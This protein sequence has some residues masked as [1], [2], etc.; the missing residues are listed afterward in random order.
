[1]IFQTQN[2]IN[3]LLIFVFCGIISALFLNIL[4]CIFFINYQKNIKK[5]ILNVV[6]YSFFN[7]FFIFLLNFFNF[8]K[9][10]FVLL[11]FFYSSFLVTKKLTRKSVVLIEKKCYNIF[12]NLKLK[13]TKQNEQ[14]KKS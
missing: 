6:F 3:C 8:G 4:K 14:S 1:M 13:R 10:S 11:S 9:F 7:I 5:I 12:N 2:Q